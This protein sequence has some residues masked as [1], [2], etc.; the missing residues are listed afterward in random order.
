MLFSIAHRSIVS[1][2]SKWLVTRRFTSNA[3]DKEIFLRTIP[4]HPGISAL[5]FNRPQSKNAISLRLLKE[6][7]ECLEEA[8]FDNNIRVLVVG[9]TTPGSFCAGADLIER[10]SM[11]ELQVNKFL[12]DLRNALNRLENL[13]VPTIAAIDGPAL[14]GGLELALACDLRVAGH[15]VTKIGLPET[16]LGIIPGAGGTQRATRLLGLSKAKDLIFTGRS[17]DA[18]EAKEWGL[19]N[20]VSDEGVSAIDRSLI[21]AKEISAN[22]PL[23]LRSA[24]QAIFRAPELALESGLDFERA[25]YDPLLRSKDRIEALQAFR[26]KR[27]PIFK[28]E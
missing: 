6:L 8:H 10:R 17:L 18:K 16:K 27:P 7:T 5:L 22:A 19:V 4:T 11:S 23:A 15:S 20:Y 21:L 12:K 26:E 2:G 25:V 13:P 3:P 24:K 9:S 28:G 1:R 14:G